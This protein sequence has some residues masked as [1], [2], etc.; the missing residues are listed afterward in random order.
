MSVNGAKS[1]APALVT[2]MCT[3]PSSVRTFE[4]FLNGGAV[5]DISGHPECRDALRA[6]LFGDPLRR[7]AVEVEN[8]HLVPTPAK[9]VARRFAIPEAPPVTTA[10]RVIARSS[11]P[12]L[13]DHVDC[14]AGR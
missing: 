6:Q 8:S 4:G 12:S 1:T 10:T 11:A 13:V 7:F 14:L 2:R 9:L 5:A 3:G